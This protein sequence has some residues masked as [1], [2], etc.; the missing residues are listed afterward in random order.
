MKHIAG[1]I[2]ISLFAV[3]STAWASSSLQEY[4]ACIHAL[5]QQ[6]QTA[7]ENITD[8]K[9]QAIAEVCRHK[10]A[11]EAIWH[12]VK[13]KQADGV[14]LQQAMSLCIAS[15]EHVDELT[16]DSQNAKQKPEKIHDLIHMHD[17]IFWDHCDQICQDN[18]G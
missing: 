5:R 18:Y 14:G 7:G 1:L 8:E 13:H 9:Q 17:K 11:N 16:L 6:A 12:C 15:G 4:K 10:V 3:T 2:F